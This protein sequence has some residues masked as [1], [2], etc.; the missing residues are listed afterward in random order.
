VSPD[1][2]KALALGADAIAIG[3]AALIACA[4]QQYRICHTGLC[5]V[6]VTTQTAELRERLRSDISAKKLEHFL[7]VSTD[8]L[9]DFARLT[10]NNDVHHLSIRNLCT[11]SSEISNHTEIPHV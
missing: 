4:C 7:R 10:G 1:F 2:A 6:G 3:I 5:P 9:K 11:T 8:E